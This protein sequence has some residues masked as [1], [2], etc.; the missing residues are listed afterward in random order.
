[1]S[2]L[3]ELYYGNVN[4]KSDNLSERPEIFEFAKS[5]EENTK[6]LSDFLNQLPNSE[7]EQHMFLQLTNARSEILAFTDRERFIEGFR[8]GAQLMFET[9]KGNENHYDSM[10]Y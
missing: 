10:I 4:P 2:T 1:M 9:C 6:K 8:L 3:E 5:A 7:K